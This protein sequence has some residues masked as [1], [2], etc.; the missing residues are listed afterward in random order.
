MSPYLAQLEANLRALLRYR[1][2]ALA[3]SLTQVFW[4]LLRLLIFSAFYASLGPAEPP[5][6][7]ARA[8]VDYVW[9]GQ[10]L[11]VLIPLRADAE[12]A[13]LVREGG[14]AYELTRPVDL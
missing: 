13:T 6:M 2:A 14:I 12:I 5:P 4:G 8:M 3:G 9:L 7:S 11:F 10:A 1:V